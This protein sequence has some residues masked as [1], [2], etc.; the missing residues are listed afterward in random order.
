VTTP[1]KYDLKCG[2]TFN[3]QPFYLTWQQ[4]HQCISI[5]CVCISA[6]EFLTKPNMEAKLSYRYIYNGTTQSHD[7]NYRISVS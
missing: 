6:Y 2:A 1:L 4:I 3:Y 7:D 5:T